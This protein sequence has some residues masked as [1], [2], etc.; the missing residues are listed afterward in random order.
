MLNEMLNSQCRAVSELQKY[1]QETQGNC[2]THGDFIGYQSKWKDRI[3]K[4]GCP[5]CFSLEQKELY[6]EEQKKLF[7]GYRKDFKSL[8]NIIS[9]AS[10]PLGFQE[11]TFENYKLDEIEHKDQQK[12]VFNA[13]KFFAS[14]FKL[15]IENNTHGIFV[16]YTGCGKSH[17]ACAIIKEVM[18]Q[19]YSGYFVTLSEIV[20]SITGTWNKFSNLTEAQIIRKLVDLD[21]LIIDEC[22]VLAK[23]F[24]TSKLF[25]I[26]NF[27]YSNKRPTILLT[28]SLEDARH[29]IGDRVISR[30]EEGDFIQNFN[31][32][33]YRKKKNV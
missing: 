23:D 18:Q 2:A 30:I 33:D 4:S 13:C 28:N 31:W 20:T 10:I 1:T 16:G 22:G 25:D 6:A 14:N 15:M 27:R 26:L 8:E 32:T 29:K 17:L 21:L 11:C 9:R 24:D 19:G 5:K 12:H 7:A 3:I